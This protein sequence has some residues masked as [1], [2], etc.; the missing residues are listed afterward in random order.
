V[1][2][3]QV[4]ASGRANE[5]IT[6]DDGVESNR[7]ITLRGGTIPTPARRFWRR[8]V[9]VT[10]AFGAKSSRCWHSLFQSRGA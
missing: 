8:R 4:E 2:F 3:T 9:P 10:T 6:P 1:G 7:F 5:W